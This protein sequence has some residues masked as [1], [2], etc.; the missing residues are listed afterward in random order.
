MLKEQIL[1]TPLSQG[2]SAIISA[3]ET[4]PF[5]MENKDGY[6]FEADDVIHLLENNIDSAGNLKTDVS[7]HAMIDNIYGLN[8]QLSALAKAQGLQVQPIA[9][10]QV[11]KIRASTEGMLF[12]KRKWRENTVDT[13]AS[14]EP[15]LQK[16]KHAK[17]IK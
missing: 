1:Q 10:Q 7:N 8:Q 5:T 4:Y 9:K 13:E 16:P 17:L 6:P 3:L 2:V 15:T 12:S 14:K 11:D